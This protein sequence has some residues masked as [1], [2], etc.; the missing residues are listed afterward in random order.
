[1]EKEKLEKLQQVLALLNAANDKALAIREGKAKDAAATA[2]EVNQ[3]LTNAKQIW[4]QH[5][6]SQYVESEI[7]IGTLIADLSDP[8]DTKTFG[9]GKIGLMSTINLIVT[10]LVK[11]KKE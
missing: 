3:D 4:D 2:K 6:L 7:N 1:M 8:N 5:G 11:L 10:A 9:L